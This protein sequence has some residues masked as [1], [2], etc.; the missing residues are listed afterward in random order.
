MIGPA[1]FVWVLLALDVGSSVF[2]PLRDSAYGIYLI[3]YIP[4]L[5]LQYAL[6]DL[7]LAPVMQVTAIIKAVI[8]FVLTL[9]FSWAA[10]AALR[11]LP[12]ATHVL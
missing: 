11:K 7:S 1:W 6:Y 2:D 12:G 9:A 8:V 5:W 10:T 4:V 3:H